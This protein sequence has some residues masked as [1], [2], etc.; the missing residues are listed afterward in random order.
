MGEEGLLGRRRQRRAG[1]GGESSPLVQAEDVRVTDSFG[2]L[3]GGVAPGFLGAYLRFL[4]V[5]VLG[6]VRIRCLGA[7]GSAA[8]GSR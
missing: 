1:A 5:A 3:S 2:L 8:N 6:T 4:L 7:D